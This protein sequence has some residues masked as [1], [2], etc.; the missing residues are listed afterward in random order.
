MNK[1]VDIS[2]SIVELNSF[3]NVVL[4]K[5]E[6]DNA[7]IVALFEMAYKAYYS[8]IHEFLVAENDEASERKIRRYVD[9]I[10]KN[11]LP[12][13]EEKLKEIKDME[14]AG[15]YLS[16]YDDFMSLAAF[17]NLTRY[18]EYLE[19]DLKGLDKVLTLALENNLIQPIFYAS[20]Q[21][22]L[23]GTVKKLFK[24]TPTGYYKTYSD[25]VIISWILG[26]NP[27]APCLK[28]VG[29][30]TM[31]TKAI[32]SVSD[33]LLSDRYAKVFPFYKQYGGDSQKMFRILAPKAGEMLLSHT[34]GVD[35][36]LLCISKGT[37][38]DGGRFKYRFYDDITNSKYKTNKTMHQVDDEYYNDQWKKRNFSEHDDCEWF[39]GTV[40]YHIDFL[41]KRREANGFDSAVPIPQ[42]RY[43]KF[44]SL[45]KAVFVTTPKLDYDTDEST[46]PQKYSTETARLERDRDFE[47]FMAMEQG[48]P[49]VPEGLAF[50]RTRMKQWE[51]L[52][53]KE[54]EGGNRSDYCMAAMDLPRT[55]DNNLCLAIFS[56]CSDLYYWVDA[57]YQKKPLDEKL[58]NGDTVLDM[59]CDKIVDR[60]IKHLV[61][62]N[63]VCS[64]I[65]Q[66][67]LD[68][69]A[70]RS[71][72]CVVD[73]IYSYMKK[74]DKIFD[75]QADIQ[76]HIVIPASG[77]FAMSSDMGKAVFDTITWN[78]KA[79][80]DDAPDTLAMFVRHFV[81]K[82]SNQVAEVRTFKR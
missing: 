55:G 76:N 35:F 12:F 34:S 7:K 32:N 28:V 14:L 80:E 40:Y 1:K 58:S 39:T 6:T 33:K 36:S 30:P 62:E 18:A 15:E 37:S 78:A 9:F 64:N 59:V 68:K 21:M 3:I 77:I 43:T 75:A 47:T 10:D 20:Q 81:K 60:N 19:F 71:Y 74:V 52:P 57:I 25:V 61:V 67:I 54:S 46:F 72:S 42:F 13:I 69:L 17:R 70:E 8:Q 38:I 48:L 49:V 26:V 41:S 22:V 45:H 27:S 66:Q 24:S 51:E 63:N 50:D 73:D 31:V 23:E 16:L 65:K 56:K 4:K 5:R 29:N 53:L 11:I 79:N 2:E 82:A 44:N